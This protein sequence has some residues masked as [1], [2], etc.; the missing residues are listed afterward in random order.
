MSK[1]KIVYQDQVTE[2]G[3]ACISMISHAFKN[4]FHYDT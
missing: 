2:C 1:A 4:Q 3:L